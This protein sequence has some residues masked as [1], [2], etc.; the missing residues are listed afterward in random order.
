MNCKLLLCCAYLLLFSVNANS[1]FAQ[2][3][4]KE[5][6]GFVKVEAEHFSKQ[7]QTDKRQWYVVD[8]NSANLPAPDP[9]E[10]HFATASYQNS[11]KKD[12]DLP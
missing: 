10:S 7:V 3:K 4:Y 12:S 1:L 11:Q 9:D 5:K 2:K 8:A 6:K